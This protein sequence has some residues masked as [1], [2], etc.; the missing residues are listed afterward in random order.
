MWRVSIGALVDIALLAKTIATEQKEY[1][2]QEQEL[3]PPF[4][5]DMKFE[6]DTKYVPKA[7]LKAEA[8]DSFTEAPKKKKMAKI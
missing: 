2:A 8:K 5:P 4:V 1:I 7:Y 6:F 3:P